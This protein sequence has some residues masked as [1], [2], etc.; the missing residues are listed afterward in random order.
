MFTECIDNYTN[1]TVS[2]FTC[3]YR[4]WWEAKM[5]ARLDI[6]ASTFMM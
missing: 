1:F 4:E 3:H 5:I 2:D 6:M